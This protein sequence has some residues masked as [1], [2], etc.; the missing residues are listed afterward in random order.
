MDINLSL[1]SNFFH[2]LQCNWLTCLSG[3]LGLS[4]TLQQQQQL[5]KI[6]FFTMAKIFQYVFLHSY[7]LSRMFLEYWE[8]ESIYWFHIIP[9]IAIKLNKILFFVLLNTFFINLFSIFRLKR[10]GKN[11]KKGNMAKFER[12]IRNNQQ[13]TK[14]P[15]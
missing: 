4:W 12:K 6:F 1:T 5:A 14:I 7:I 10:H 3:S 13:I 8:L 11:G 2:I 15:V 9:Y